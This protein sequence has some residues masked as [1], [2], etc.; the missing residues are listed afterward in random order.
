M[1]KLKVKFTGLDTIISPKSLNCILGISV[2]QPYH[3]GEKLEAI[4]EEINENFSRCFVE[5][6]DSLQRYNN[7][8]LGSSE[9]KAYHEAVSM[10]ETWKERNFEIIQK[11]KIPYEVH[12][13]DKWILQKGSTNQIVDPNGSIYLSLKLNHAF[14]NA[15][16]FVKNLYHTDH[17]YRD[18]LEIAISQIFVSKK[19]N[20]S[21]KVG[22]SEAETLIQNY[23]EEELAVVLL[24]E[25]EIG[26]SVFVYP[27]SSGKAPQRA[28]EC[29][30]KLISSIPQKFKLYIGD[31]QFFTINKQASKKS[32]KKEIELPPSNNQLGNRSTENFQ[33]KY[34]FNFFETND[35][36]SGAPRTIT[37]AS[38]SPRKKE[39][40]FSVFQASTIA[41]FQTETKSEKEKLESYTA[42]LLYNISTLPNTTTPKNIAANKV[43]R[44]SM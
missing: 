10:G 13:W 19:N 6:G 11:L 26:N 8:M 34:S 33:I 30:K 5:I 38:L 15:L 1:T 3:E 27:N 29:Y 17:E 24:W 36:A 40:I 21:C 32:T 22:K 16:K 39:L 43:K 7:L 18:T 20:G 25:K 12:S 42:S 23:I 31:I 37:E 9:E 4:I 35:I 14:E 2:G 41:L 44:F 28:C